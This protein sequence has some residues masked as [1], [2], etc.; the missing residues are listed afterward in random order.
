MEVTPT[1]SLRRQRNLILALLLALAAGAWALL[2]WQAAHT[3]MAAT[4]SPTMGMSAALWLSIWVAMMV[5]IMFPTA[6]PMM[7]MFAQVHAAKRQRQQPFVPTWLFVSSYLLVWA[8][9]GV[10]AYAAAAGADRLAAESM[11]LMDFGSRLGGLVL[12]GAGLYQLSPQKH[13]CLAKC[14]SPLAFI[15]TSWRDGYSGAFS[16]GLK[17]ASYCLGCCWL[18]FVILFPLGML[19]LAALALISLF[20]FAEKSLPHGHQIGKLGG[21]LLIP[22]GL[23]TL[24]IPQIL[25]TMS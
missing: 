21:M 12:I 7:L 25:P 8:L 14:R 17:H 6:A 24:A 18:L 11:F 2:I 5:A 16:M 9:T 23:V 3:G 15:M 4:M 19:N 1:Y 20:I 10:L 22:F 13:I